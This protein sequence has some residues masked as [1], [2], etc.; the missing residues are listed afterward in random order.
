[1]VVHKRA[2]VEVNYESSYMCEVRFE[3]S[4]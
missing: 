2:A 1:M 4:C 3:E